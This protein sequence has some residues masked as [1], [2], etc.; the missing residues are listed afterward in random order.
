MRSLSVLVLFLLA[1]TVAAQG[2]GMGRGGPGGDMGTIH[3]LLTDHDAIERRVVDLPDGVETWTESDDPAVAENI[4][5]H[6]HAMDARLEDGRPIR[7]WDPL[8]AEIFEHADAIDMVIE[9]TPRGVRVVET[10]DDAY[11][12]TLIQQ[13]AHRA[14][15]EFIA[16]GMERAHDPT[17]MPSAPGPAISSLPAYDDDAFASAPLY[18]GTARVIGFAFRAG[19]ALS[20]HTVAED[21]YLLVVEGAARVTVGDTVH[22]LGAG[23]GVVLPGGVPHALDADEDTRIAVVR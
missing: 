7:R 3:S 19:Q 6:V 14:V 9:D 18:D 21:A 10:S 17:P 4:R 8:F 16:D 23:E 22:T 5:E 13:H 12:V 1:P 11:V 15:S 2:P 20:S